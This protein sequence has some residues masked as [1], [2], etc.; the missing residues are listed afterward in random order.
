MSLCVS[1]F[2]KSFHD[3]KEI[4]VL[5]IME[6]AKFADITMILSDCQIASPIRINVGRPEWNDLLRLA[7]LGY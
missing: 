7:S 2:E 3:P 5:M 1:V 6:P 4:Q